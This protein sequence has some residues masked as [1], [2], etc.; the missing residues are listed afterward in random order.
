MVVINVINQPINRHKFD[1]TGYWE[2]EPENLP[3]A[4]SK[5]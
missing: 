2:H 1:T 4:F 5:I 3:G